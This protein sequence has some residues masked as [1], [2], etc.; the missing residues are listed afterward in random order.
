M[1]ALNQLNSSL[2]YLYLSFLKFDIL[3]IHINK[4]LKAK[5]CLMPHRLKLSRQKPSFRKYYNAIF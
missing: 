4:Y 3:Q 1:E 2:R 5:H